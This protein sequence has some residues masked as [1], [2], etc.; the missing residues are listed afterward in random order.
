MK[1]AE[2]II[3]ILVIVGLAC[4][5]SSCSSPDPVT[6]LPPRGAVHLYT[7]NDEVKFRVA[8]GTEQVLPRPQPTAMA[9]N[10]AI[11]VDGSGKAHLRF[12]DYLVVDI[13][14]DTD[15]QINGLS[16]PDAPPAY[17]LRLEGGSTFNTINVQEEA[18][19]R[20]QPSVEFETDWAVIRTVG[21][22]FFTHFDTLQESTW[23]IVKHGDVEVEAEG[24]TV[25]VSTGEQ[26]WVESGSAPI[27][28]LPACRELV[29]DDGELFPKVEKLTNGAITDSYL[30]PCEGQ[31]AVAITS[32][33]SPTPTPTPTPKV[34]TPNRSRIPPKVLANYFAWFDGDGWDDCNISAGDKPLQT[35]DSDDPDAIV[36]HIRMARNANIDGF[37]IQWVGP[38]NRTDRNFATLL[39]KSLG[40]DFQSTVVFLSHFWFGEASQGDVIEALRYLQSQY[41]GHPNFLQIQ[42]RPTIFITDVYRVPVEG[43]QSP[44][45][46]WSSIRDQVDPNNEYLWIA[47]G[48]DP[49]YLSVFDGLWVYKVSHAAYPNDYIKASRWASG[50]RTWEKRTGKTKLWVATLMPGWDDRRASCRADSRVP[51]Q[52]FVRPRENGG[53]YRATFNAAIKSN[54]DILWIHSFN[55]WVEGTYVEP[56]Q[57]YGDTY[58]NLTRELAKEFKE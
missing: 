33:S 57:Q 22:A 44:Q 24:V 39:D 26:T 56:S 30:L 58:I 5:S 29:G 35:Y 28:P 41:G 34:V 52:P 1:R 37:T 45:Q 14:R 46:A 2:M 36:D 40:T 50:V 9:L 20:V 23:V 51:S 55:E 18:H 17:R 43:G 19:R 15:L 7:H 53:F 49:S 27:Q 8:G 47:E 32:I 16:A 6:P 4:F 38:D 10:D 21:T 12:A 13:F 31:P 11:H 42:G 3:L 48:L 54:P 25:E